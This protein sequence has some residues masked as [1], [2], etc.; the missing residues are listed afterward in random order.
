MEWIAHAPQDDPRRQRELE[1]DRELA[2]TAMSDVASWRPDDPI[3]IDALTALLND[4]VADAIEPAWG[5]WPWVQRLSVAGAWLGTQA[6]RLRPDDRAGRWA[7]RLARART[8]DEVRAI[9]LD[10][11]RNLVPGGRP[12]H[13]H[14][15]AAEER[16]EGLTTVPIRCAD[17]LIG[18]L[19][20]DA[21]A[22]RRAAGPRL[23]ALE[24]LAALA[25]AVELAL[26]EPPRP[27]QAAPLVRDPV[28]GLHTEAFLD[29]FLDQTMAL[30]RRRG[31]P[32]SLLV[33][34]LDGLDRIADRD[35]PLLVDAALGIAARALTGTLRGSDLVT[36]IERN[37]FAAVLPAAA[38]EDA[39]RVAEVVRRAQA[40]AGLT[41]GARRP[42][43]A[44]I[45]LATRPDH[46]HDA[47][48][49]RQQAEAA[50][51]RAQ[52][53]GGNRVVVP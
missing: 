46:A 28:T 20:L 30:A 21:A 47:P 29:A 38:R 34:G 25:A 53:S 32:L 33:L 36:R 43:T 9:L 42:L 24:T 11:A 39:A 27:G 2:R 51:E 52:Q 45:G 26:A 48:S 37:R 40:E 31:E 13:V 5:A 23:R 35:G 16:I 1:T 4:P 18:G 3:A 7:R 15:A 17:R 19:R 6:R 44:S 49:L 12:L 8:V 41:S 22:V 10:A 50:L 14:A